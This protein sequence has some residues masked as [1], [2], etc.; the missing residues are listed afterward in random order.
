M[1]ITLL[2]ACSPEP[3]PP[4]PADPCAVTAAPPEGPL[5]AEIAA[6]E[7]PLA[8]ARL[9]IRQARLSADPGYYVLAGQAADCALERRPEDVEARRIKVHVLIQ[10][11]RFAE[12]EAAARE[13]VARERSGWFD[14]LLL[15]DALMEQGKLREAG[16]AYQAA[17]DR[18][19]SLQLYDRAAWMRWLVGDLEGAIDL[20]R[21]AVRAGSPADPEPLA[22]VLTRLGWL[23]ALKGEPAPELDAALELLP[24]YAPAHLRRGQLRLYRG[25]L[26]GAREDLRAVGATVAAYRAL[27]ELDPEIDVA[28][29]GDQDY[30]GFG[31][32]LADREPERAVALLEREYAARQDAVTT[33]ALAYAR[34]R[35]GEGGPELEAA[36]REAL[37]TGIIEPRT[38]LHAGW[39]LG[40]RTLVERALS[41]GPGL[42][43]SERARAEGG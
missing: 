14:Q 30:R 11:H 16:A 28:A 13:L 3:E 15:G 17:M 5:A 24:D 23:R 37:A 43:P 20:Q 34:S 7:D 33:I 22:W 32:W 29:V 18:R 12:A 31:E 39:I 38:L 27:A 2:L 42:L 8:I 6:A 36:V 9:Q 21:R 19:P 4:G 35:A 41:M 10:F 40:D 1:L 26:E 25:E